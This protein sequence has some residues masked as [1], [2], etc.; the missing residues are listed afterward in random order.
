MLRS[1]QTIATQRLSFRTVVR[2]PRLPM[3]KPEE[4]FTEAPGCGGLRCW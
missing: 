3:K 2:W 1:V 4:A